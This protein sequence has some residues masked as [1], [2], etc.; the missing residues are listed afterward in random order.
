[1]KNG[2][3]GKLFLSGNSFYVKV[4]AGEFTYRDY[5]TRM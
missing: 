4:K 3:I 5:F 1:M 2:G